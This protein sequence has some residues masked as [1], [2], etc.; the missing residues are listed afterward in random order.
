VQTGCVLV[1]LCYVMSSVP[2]LRE[3][4]NTNI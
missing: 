1:M 4:H 2:P 3:V